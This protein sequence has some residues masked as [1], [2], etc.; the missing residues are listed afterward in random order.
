MIFS[1]DLFIFAFLP[2]ALLGLVLARR[3]FGAHL[4]WIVIVSLFF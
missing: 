3:L 1:S 2:L 4:Y